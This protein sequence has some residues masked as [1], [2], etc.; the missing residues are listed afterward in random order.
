MNRL[1]LAVIAGGALFATPALAQ[2]AT[3]PNLGGTDAS[4]DMSGT[5]PA[6]STGTETAPSVDAAAT[7]TVDMGAWPQ[8]AIERPYVRPKSSIAAYAQFGLAAISVPAIPPATTGGTATLDML[9]VGGAYGVTDKITAGLQYA[10]SLGLGDGDFEA[11]GPLTVY[12]EYQIVHS[13]K[14]SIAASANFTYDV[15]GETSEIDAG[16]GARY[17]LAPKMALYTGAPFGPGPVGQHLSISLDDG[18]IDFDVPV[19]FAYQASPQLMAF[20]STQLATIHFNP[21]M[22]GDSVTFIGDSIPLTLGGLYALNKTL[23]L[24][25]S[26]FIDLAN[27]GDFWGFTLG[28]NYYK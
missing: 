7:T 17:T 13:D 18:P 2:D 3:D 6:A 19:G 28:G 9:G 15:A 27:A 14:L 21:P 5:D 11:K 25:A 16:L 24:H 26:F 4:A 8:A 10:F 22:N 12:G 20:A 23:D 1:K